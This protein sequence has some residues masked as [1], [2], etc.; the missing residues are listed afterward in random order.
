MKNII[1]NINIAFI[2]YSFEA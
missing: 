1:A 2:T